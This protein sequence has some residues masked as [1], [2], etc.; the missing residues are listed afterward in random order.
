[1]NILAIN[2]SENVKWTFVKEPEKLLDFLK[3]LTVHYQK[4]DAIQKLYSLGPIDK[5]G[6]PDSENGGMDEEYTTILSKSKEYF[7]DDSLENILVN[8]HRKFNYAFYYTGENWLVAIDG[9]IC[10]VISANKLYRYMNNTEIPEKK[11]ISDLKVEMYKDIINQ[12]ILN[13]IDM[14]SDLLISGCSVNQIMEDLDSDK[15]ADF[16]NKINTV[17]SAV[18]KKMKPMVVL[19]VDDSMHITSTEYAIISKILIT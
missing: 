5:L 14:M 7:T 15:I 12:Y 9:E 13:D 3:I 10:P 6:V 16:E 19:Y 11:L 18:K 1:M 8:N 2:N 4:F 17:Y